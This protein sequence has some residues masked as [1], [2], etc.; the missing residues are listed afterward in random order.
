MEKPL[1]DMGRLLFEQANAMNQQFLTGLKAG[2]EISATAHRLL[3]A[4]YEKAKED[5]AAKIPS[6]LECAI[7]NILRLRDEEAANAYADAMTSADLAARHEGRP[8]HDTDVVG[9]A[10]A[11]GM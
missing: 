9:R 11:A 2:R 8:E 6:P 3:K 5:P 1:S 10:L 4:S 7:E